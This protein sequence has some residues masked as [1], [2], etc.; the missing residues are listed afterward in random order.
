MVFSVLIRVDGVLRPKRV[1]YPDFW[2]KVPKKKKKKTLN[3][4]LNVFFFWG[5]YP[6][7]IMHVLLPF[8]PSRQLSV[9]DPAPIRAFAWWMPASNRRQEPHSPAII[10][11]KSSIRFEMTFFCFFP[12]FTAVI[13]TWK[14][15]N[16]VRPFVGNLPHSAFFLP[17]AHE[18][19]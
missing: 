3:F 11:T 12:A 16:F 7:R 13:R 19:H 15:G 4:W 5:G 2:R 8:H 17:T 18:A 14:R 10:L 6:L 1:F 9:G